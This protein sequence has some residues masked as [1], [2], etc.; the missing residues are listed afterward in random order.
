[1]CRVSVIMPCY[2]YARFLAD[3]A[4]SILA[5]TFKDIELIIVDDGSTDDTAAVASRVAADNPGRHITI[6]YQQNAGVSAARNTGIEAACG[7]YVLPLD[8]D[9]KMLPTYIDRLVH[10][11]DT[12]PDIDLA[13]SWTGFFGEEIGVEEHGEFT[14]EN[15]IVNRGPGCTILMRKSAWRKVGGYNPV[16]D[17]SQED[18]EFG[19]N[20][21]R[22]GCRGVVVPEVLFMYRKHGAS[23]ATQGE[24]Y[25]L[26]VSR[27]IKLL[28][29]WAFEPFLNSISPSLA[30][31]AIHIKRYTRDPVARLIYLHLPGIHKFFRRLKY[32]KDTEG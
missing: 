16:L 32:G 10:V 31:M 29:P 26:D 28:H 20:L 23:R 7:E 21:F 11:L 19:L 1:M 12:R 27:T 13:Y 18:W 9:D 25:S 22:S 3:A 24:D 6:I 4:E 15:L 2:N 8:A 14:L 30:R 5:Q 17:K